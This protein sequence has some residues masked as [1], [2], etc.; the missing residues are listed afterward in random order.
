MLARLKF[1]TNTDNVDTNM[2]FTAF[3]PEVEDWK[4]M[5]LLP[6]IAEMMATDEIVKK[7]RREVMQG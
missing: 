2:E 4:R 5:K 3:R 6:D 7:W 1:G